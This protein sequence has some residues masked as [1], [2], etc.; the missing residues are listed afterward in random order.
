MFIIDY[1]LK[2]GWEY[3]DT[4]QTHTFSV[5]VSDQRQWYEIVIIIERKGKRLTKAVIRDSLKKLPFSL[6]KI[7]KDFELGV[8]KIRWGQEDYLKYRPIGYVPDSDELRYLYH[9]L[10][11]AKRGLES[12][13][14]QG[15]NGLTIAGDAMSHFE[16][17]IGKKQYKYL[18]PQ[19]DLVVDTDIRSSYKGGYCYIT[20]HARD[21]IIG[22]GIVFDVNS[23][24]PSV[25]YNRFLP[26]GTPVFFQG[27][28]EPDATH[29]L[30]IQKFSCRYKLK[31][32]HLPTIQ[33]K[34]S[35]FGGY[36][37]YSTQSG[38]ED[39]TLTLTSIDLKLFFE[40]YEVWDIDY[41]SGYKF[42]GQTGIFKR[43]ID[44][45]MYMKTH[46]KGAVKQ[47]AKLM[48][49]SLYGKFGTNPQ[50]IGR[51]PILVN[52]KIEFENKDPEFKKTK[53]VPMATFITA[54]AREL[55]I[56]TGQKVYDRLLYS[57]TDSIHLS[58]WEIPEEIKDMIDDNEM[59][60]W[61][62][63]S[64]F[65]RAKFLRPKRYIEQLVPRRKLVGYQSAK[66]LSQ[67]RSEW[68]VQ[69][70]FKKYNGT[71]NVKCGGLNDKVKEQLTWEE[72]NIGYETDS[73]LRPLTVS[74]GIALV[75]RQFRM[76]G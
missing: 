5:N 53:Y 19:L 52:D 29:P 27:K 30:F 4:K 54:Y 25:M 51:I 69:M 64:R 65:T 36:A 18:F 43:Y 70:T 62:L 72:F 45:W 50:Q 3:D 38:D 74:G 33:S 37:E 14:K 10:L 21:K 7:G 71:M 42:A 44:K 48:L 23:L 46:Y 68:K 28:Y 41:L 57:D 1:L 6:D 20:P 39:I 47:L 73:A 66:P 17:S 31:K 24:Y 63:E 34:Q 56:R 61:Q 35:R 2:S 58:G 16:L 11:V 49:N 67:Y 60:K 59:G 75:P 26:V 55:T 32:D 13:F 9:D 22:K 76:K 15:L 12:Q 8:K 40:H